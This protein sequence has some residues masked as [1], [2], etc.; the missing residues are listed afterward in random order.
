MGGKVGEILRSHC[1]AVCL[2][3]ASFF[4]KKLPPNV[5]YIHYRKHPGLGG[6][7]WG[8]V[9]SLLTADLGS[10]LYYIWF[11]GNSQK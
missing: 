3:D 9:L 8:K 6:M 1:A 2:E 10:S 5:V 11:P 7:V 4:S